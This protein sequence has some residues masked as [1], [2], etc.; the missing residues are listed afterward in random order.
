MSAYRIPAW[1]VSGG[2]PWLSTESWDIAA[3]LPPNVPTDKESLEHEVELML[4]ALVAD[5]FDLSTHRE[6]R[7]Q[8]TYALVVTSGGSKLKTS[9]ASTYSAKRGSGH[10]ELHHATMAAFV[11]YLYT[12]QAYGPQAVDRPVV[13]L[14]GLTGFFDLTLDW[15]PDSSQPDASG[16]SLFT[17]LQE[18]TGLRLEP[19]KSA[20]EFLIIDRSVRPREN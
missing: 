7:D 9:A 19:R 10:L 11:S 4:Q 8:P 13:D 6:T 18:Q 15:V 12:P 17:A 3:T 20:V 2:P 5:R 14:T 16:P 1:R